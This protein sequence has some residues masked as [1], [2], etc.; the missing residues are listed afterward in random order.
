MKS[1]I[2]LTHDKIITKVKEIAQDLDQRYANKTP[3]VVGIMKGS[4]FF[5]S[6]L[7]M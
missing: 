4:L 6:D 2:I 3:V 7:T 1:E 5:L